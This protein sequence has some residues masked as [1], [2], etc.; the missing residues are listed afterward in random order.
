[1]ANLTNPRN[2]IPKAYDPKG[3]EGPIYDMWEE[4]GYFQPDLSSD[5]QAFCIMMPPPNVT[6][7]LH[8]GHALTAA[9]E[10][11][12]TR[13]HRMQGEPT[14]WLPGV[15]H[16]GIATQV[17][18]EANLAKEGLTRHDLGREAFLERV[19]EWV[20]RHRDI[21]DQQHKRLGASC[22]WSRERFTMDEGPQRAVRATFSNLYHD[23]LIYRGE[24]IINW[25]PRCMTALSDLEVD[26]QDVR[27]SFWHVRY[28]LADGDGHL[29]IATTRPETMVADVAVAVNPNDERY[30]H[31]IG[32][33]VVLPIIGRR[34][35]VVADEAVDLATGT[36]ALKI[37]PGHDPVDF[38]IGQRHGLPTIVAINLDATMNAEAGPYNGMDRFEARK[39]IV[40][41]LEEQGFIEKIEPHIHAIGHCQRCRTIVEPIVSKQWFVKMEPLAQPALAAMRDGR[42]KFMPNHY[43]RIYEHWLENIRDWCIS[44]QL[45]WGHRIPAWYCQDCGALIVPIKEDPTTDPERCTNCGSGHLEQDPDVLD[46]WFSS[47]LWPHSTLGW[48]ED[49]ED[50]R[51]FYPTSVMETAYDILFFW[52]ARM[53]MMGL[54]NM[55]GEVPFRTVYLHGLIRDEKGEKM[56]K[57]RG[58]VVDPLELIDAF[59]T[60]GVRFALATG[61]AAHG[62][63]ERLA[64]DRLESGRNFANKLWNAARYVITS[65]GDEVVEAPGADSAAEL[66]MED[67]WILS[68]LNRTVQEVQSLLSDFQIAE[69]GKKLYDFVWSEYCDWYIEMSKV[70][71]REGDRSP[72]PVLAHVLDTSLRLLHPYM[73]FVTEM[74]WQN[75]KSRLR[76]QDAEALI[77][78]SWP[79]W[80]PALTDSLAERDMG[81]IDEAVTAIRFIRAE[82]KVEA[83][84]WVSAYLAPPFNPDEIA[85]FTERLAGETDGIRRALLEDVINRPKRLHTELKRLSSAISTLARARPIEIFESGEQ[86]PKVQGAIDDIGG[87]PIRVLIP[88]VTNTEEMKEKLLKE[89]GELELQVNRLKERLTNKEFRN[90]APAHVVESDEERL[91]DAETRLQTLRQRLAE[92]SG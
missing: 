78:A 38:K 15:D 57:S 60:D 54:Y 90:K 10:D 83:S 29:T 22:D 86:M 4:R 87:F 18:V 88:I 74:I 66:P 49:T 11:I 77:I 85:D 62:H 46:T 82:H 7:E 51:T 35:P 3:V 16:A 75:L 34:L 47:G 53:I 80:N 42:I 44:R 28:P 31:L 55:K 23:G 76:V 71:L 64:R 41:D 19:W 8:L 2:E 26:H 48:P 20:E 72:L 43:E 12:L 84:Q 70:R 37:T 33:E 73:P 27:G 24:R 63:D 25:C 32:R 13:W 50:L 67:R 45:W 30:K 92:L 40:R 81:V 9:I 58:N 56:S 21:I 1:M 17:V 65:L 14:L 89:M 36:G 52:V 39:A 79:S 5:K 59:G 69:A 91:R 68:R 6:G 61:A